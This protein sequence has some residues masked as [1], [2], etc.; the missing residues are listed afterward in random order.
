M[1]GSGFSGVSVSALLYFSTLISLTET[2]V[3]NSVIFGT[4]IHVP[5]ID[6]CLR[7]RSCSSTELMILLSRDSCLQQRFMFFL[8][9]NVGSFP[10]DSCSFFASLTE[11]YCSTTEI[12]VP[13]QSFMLSR[14]FLTCCSFKFQLRLL[15]VQ[16]YKYFIF[17][18]RRPL[19]NF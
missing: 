7:K 15:A 6:S 14:L 10:R 11:V 17:F 9:L 16:F 12:F 4:E 5:N 18:S 19:P 8:L 3:L 13:Q 2:H 1:W